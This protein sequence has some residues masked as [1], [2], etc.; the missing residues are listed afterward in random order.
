MVNYNNGKIYCIK[1][2]ED[3]E[4]YV[5]STTVP[6]YKRLGQHKSDAE[7]RSRGCLHRHMSALGV[8]KF[9]IELIEDCPCAN[10]SILTAREGVYI[11]DVG[12]LNTLINGRTREEYYE[13]NKE[14][15]REYG[16]AR[17]R[18]AL[19]DKGKEPREPRKHPQEPGK[20]HCTKCHKTLDNS[21]FVS[22]KG[23]VYKQCIPC[24]TKWITSWK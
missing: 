17:Y 1:N 22:D 8:D 14:K 5:G 4:V 11:R 21:L 9:Y 18:E 3:D 15:K 20:S 10:K 23:K 24:K 19:R 16:R 7:R 6:L 12:T 13:Q 2:T